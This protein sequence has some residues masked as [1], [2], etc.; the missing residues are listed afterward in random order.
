MLFPDTYSAIKIHENIIG[1][2]KLRDFGLLDSAI[3]AAFICFDDNE[4]F[5]TP[6]EKAAK[7]LQHVIK[8]HPFI[9]GNKRTAFAIM[10]EILLENQLDFIYSEAEIS[11]MI[12]FLEEIAESKRNYPEILEFISSHIVRRFISKRFVFIK[13][14]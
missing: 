13:S 7:I 6:H 12:C 11:E 10:R 9:D 1:E 3:N 8:N 4:E 2:N 14:I 5:K